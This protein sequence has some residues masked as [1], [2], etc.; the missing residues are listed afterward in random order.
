MSAAEAL[1]AAH[2]AGI[3]VRIDGDDLVLEASAPPS[4]AMLDLL[5]RHKADIVALLRSADGR[6]GISEFDGGL[7]ALRPRLEPSPAAWPNG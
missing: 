6:A 3:G 7:R 4:P 5:S 1:M 2:A